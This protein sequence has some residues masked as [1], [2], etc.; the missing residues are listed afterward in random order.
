MN[1]IFILDQLLVLQIMAVDEL[2]NK[3]NGLSNL[4]F[5]FL[6]DNI[7]KDLLNLIHVI[8]KVFYFIFIEIISNFI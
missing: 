4:R 8:N 5:F 1:E 6:L 3:A 2:A 7:I